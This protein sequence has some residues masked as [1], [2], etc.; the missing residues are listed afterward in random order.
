MIDKQAYI[1]PSA[2][3]A[4][5]VKIG[6]WSYIAENVSIAEG[7]IIEP[8]VV[9]KPNVSIGRGN[10]IYQFASIGEAPQHTG[11]KGEP[12]K[13]SI[14]DNNIIREYVSI[15]RATTEADGVTSIGDRNF[16]MCYAHVAHD[17]RVGSDNVFANNASIAG[18]VVVEDFVILGGFTGVHQ[19]CHIGAYSFLG[20]ATKIVQDIVPYTIVSGNPGV[21]TAINSVGLRRHGFSN[22]QVRAIKDAFS[23]IFRQGHPHAKA[24]EYLQLQSEQHAVLKP[25][26]TMLRDSQRGVARAKPA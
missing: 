18:H 8:H 15:H 1:H 9:I 14:G 13:V 7:T 24:L 11:Y 16:M 2:Q 5:D 10:H 12:T 22:A 25:L 19:F 21:P 6:P 20:R 23:Y 4:D 26:L 17:C 3:I